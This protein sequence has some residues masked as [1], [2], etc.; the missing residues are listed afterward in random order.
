MQRPSFNKSS[1]IW[2][3]NIIFHLHQVAITLPFPLRFTKNK[4]FQ[5]VL[6]KPTV[7]TCSSTATKFWYH[8]YQLAISEQTYHFSFS[9]PS[10]MSLVMLCFSRLI[11]IINHFVNKLAWCSFKP[12]LEKGID[13][14][15]EFGVALNVFILLWSIVTEQAFPKFLED[16]PSYEW[17]HY[18]IL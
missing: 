10:L 3:S 2:T 13:R 17:V 4:I 1:N 14:K 15:F 12:F 6:I 7:L 8:F 18:T 9:I 16:C 5:I 11:S